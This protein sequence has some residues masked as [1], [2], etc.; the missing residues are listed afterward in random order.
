MPGEK[1]PESAPL[2]QLKVHS[3]SLAHAL[4]ALAAPPALPK[5]LFVLKHHLCTWSGD[6]EGISG[7]PEQH[8]LLK[9]SKGRSCADQP[10]Q[11]AEALTAPIGELRIEL[12][13]THDGS[14]NTRFR[15]A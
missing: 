9:R 11:C 15:S 6:D 1:E 4:A 7:A 2:D 14:F 12:A 10:D 13:P 8:F 3:P 5:D